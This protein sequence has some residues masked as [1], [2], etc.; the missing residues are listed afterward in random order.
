MPEG[1]AHDPIHTLLITLTAHVDQLQAEYLDT[2]TP[3]ERKAAVRVELRAL[4]HTLRDV[5]LMSQGNP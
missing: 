1:E 2:D 3:P 4:L 5:L